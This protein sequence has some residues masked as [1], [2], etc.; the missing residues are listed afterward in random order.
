MWPPA[1]PP[2]SPG[3]AAPPASA[4]RDRRQNENGP[5]IA[6]RPA[7]YRGTVTPR[8]VSRS[9]EDYIRTE[10][11]AGCIVDEDDHRSAVVEHQVAIQQREVGRSDRAGSKGQF[12]RADNELD[13]DISPEVAAE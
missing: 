10:V 11:E 6:A 12:V 5:G 13:N 3:S 2:S 1:S 8:D 4:R 9:V 7:S